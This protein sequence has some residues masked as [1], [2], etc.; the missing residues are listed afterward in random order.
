MCVFV[1]V[2]TLLSGLLRDGKWPKAEPTVTSTAT[3][4]HITTIYNCWLVFTS[5]RLIFRRQLQ[6]SLEKR[7]FG[8]S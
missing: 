6:V 1:C 3:L 7:N 8:H 2:N 4:I 5:I